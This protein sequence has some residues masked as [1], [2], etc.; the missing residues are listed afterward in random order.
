MDESA[1]LRVEYVPG[2][3]RWHLVAP[4]ELVKDPAGQ[5]W[6]LLDPGIEE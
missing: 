4:V 3:Q 2:G 1:A 6:H 5:D